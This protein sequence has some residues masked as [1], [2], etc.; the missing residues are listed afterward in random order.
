VG[1]MN[2]RFLLPWNCIAL[3]SGAKNFRD[4]PYIGSPLLNR[5][6]LHLWRKKLAHALARRYRASFGKNLNEKHRNS[7]DNNGYIVE[8]DFLSAIQQ[9]E[10][11][12]ELR[13]HALPMLEM[14]Q[15]PA[16][17][18]RAYLDE[19]SCVGM[20][21]T[22][23]LLRHPLPRA[24][25]QYVAGYKGQ[26]VIAL[27]CIQSDAAKDGVQD[28]QT[29]WHTDTFHSTA[30]AWLF[31]H[32]VG[33]ESGPFAYVPGSHA[34]S[35]LRCEWEQASSETAAR[36]PNALHA[37]GSWR[38]SEEEILEM[39][40]ASPFTATVPSNTLVVADTGGFHRRTESQRHTVRIEIYYSLR[41]NPFFAGWLPSPLSLPYVR[42]SWAYWFTKICNAMHQHGLR[43]WTP[44]TNIGLHASEQ[45][46][47]KL[48]DD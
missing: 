24:L 48:E 42:S 28:P 8:H 15:A 35:P 10:L 25:L 12:R 9:K 5:W 17:T 37:K 22:L 34:L 7:Y 13:Q 38:A 16:V 33:S 44:A 3:L 14:M 30:K 2:L 20:P 26:P 45:L 19:A 21:A 31:L 39:G 1:H 11:A 27:Q 40:Y 43:V 36:H 47:L 23:A 6:G 46:L 32:D 41:R 18:R 29:V 4:N